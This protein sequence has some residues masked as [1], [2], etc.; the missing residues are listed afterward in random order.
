MHKS[1]NEI[2]HDE[3]DKNEDKTSTRYVKIGTTQIL[4]MR[5]P[6]G[7]VKSVSFLLRDKV[8]YEIN[9]C[10]HCHSKATFHRR[11]QEGGDIT[12]NVWRAEQF[13]GEKGYDFR[14]FDFCLDCHKEFLIE[15]YVWEKK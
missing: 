1:K 8:I 13:F 6:D 2:S 15:L 12:G 11:A 10:P 3:L 14:K 9:V 4:Q 7:Q 5:D